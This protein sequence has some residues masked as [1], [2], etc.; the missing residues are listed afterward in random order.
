M[1]YWWILGLGILVAVIAAPAGAEGIAGMVAPADGNMTVVY[2]TEENAGSLSVSPVQIVFSNVTSDASGNRTGTVI[3]YGAENRTDL[4]GV[5]TATAT[6]NGETYTVNTVTVTSSANI[7]LNNLLFT[8]ASGTS[9]FYRQTV[10]TGAH[11]TWI[12]LAWPSRL[13]AALDLMVYAPDATLGP[14]KDTADGISDSRIFL[15]IAGEGNVTPGDWYY[16]V[17]NQD[18]NATPY[19]LNTYTS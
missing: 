12:D 14:F 1:Q 17:R 8:T 15:D 19:T 13:N 2:L 6:S 5:F 10:K 9:A 4:P 3:A 16:R 11:E 7:P 18:G